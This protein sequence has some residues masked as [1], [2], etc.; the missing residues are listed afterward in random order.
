MKCLL[1]LLGNTLLARNWSLM[2]LGS[3]MSWSVCPWVALSQGAMGTDKISERSV[4]ST[5]GS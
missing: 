4:Q 1:A 2:L 5:P 3:V